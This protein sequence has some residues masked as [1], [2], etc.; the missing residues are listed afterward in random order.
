MIISALYGFIAYD[1]S[2]QPSERERLFIF[3]AVM[4]LGFLCTEALGHSIGI[5]LVNFP[6]IAM[7]ISIGIFF[8]L[9]LYANYQILTDDLPLILQY[10]GHFVHLQYVFNSGLLCFYGNRCGPEEKSVTLLKYGVEDTQLYP[11]IYKLAIYL[12]VLKCITYFMLIL[13][14]NFKFSYKCFERKPNQ[15]KDHNIC[16]NSTIVDVK[17]IENCKNLSDILREIHSAD[18]R[19][20]E[21]NDLSNN[22]VLNE[23]Q[24]Y[25]NKICFAW[26][27]L[28]LKIPRKLFKE[29]KVILKR[30]SGFF[31][32]GKI[33]ALMGCSG[34]GKTTLL[35]S[36]N[37]LYND[38]ITND[39]VILLS[40]FRPIRTCYI[41]QD[42]RQH[43]V[44]GLTAGQAMTYASKLKNCDPN[45]DHNTNVKNLMKQ[46][47]IDN[48]FDTNVEDCS[49]GEQKRLIIA[50][51][52]TTSLKPNLL[53]IDEP[54]SGLDSNAAE[55]VIVQEFIH[56]N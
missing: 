28:T 20:N 39:S 42:E 53:C 49:G 34:A 10:V 33:N 47:L 38:Y 3:I 5:T 12:V 2:G 27:L 25:R 50:M 37:G 29:E 15:N 32:F 55:M 24:K 17:G 11:N 23:T 16:L 30:I 41:E 44:T 6:T 8:G 43:L 21:T 14:T 46:L 19:N 13:K 7:F 51:E 22:E 56:F 35:K 31:E 26:K 52:L 1:F 40:K 18:K 45:F 36:I 9:G 48:T 4:I 54:T